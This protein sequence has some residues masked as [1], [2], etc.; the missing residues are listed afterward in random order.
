MP[1]ALLTGYAVCPAD[2]AACCTVYPAGESLKILAEFLEVSDVCIKKFFVQSAEKQQVAVIMIV[3]M[4][5]VY[6]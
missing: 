6:E 3:E 1:V 4:R 5:Y 2:S